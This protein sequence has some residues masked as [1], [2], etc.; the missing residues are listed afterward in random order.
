MDEVDQHLHALLEARQQAGIRRVQLGAVVQLDDVGG[1]V[2]EA[3]SA[4][5]AAGQGVIQSGGDSVAEEYGHA[6]GGGSERGAVPHS[7]PP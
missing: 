5:L 7:C 1:P 2:D 4:D 3:Y 6:Q